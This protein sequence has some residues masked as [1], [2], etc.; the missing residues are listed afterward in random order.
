MMNKYSD[1]KSVV[2]IRTGAP[3]M[4]TL[5]IP[6]SACGKPFPCNSVLCKG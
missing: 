1:L 6:E 5:V 2:K 4:Q 3:V